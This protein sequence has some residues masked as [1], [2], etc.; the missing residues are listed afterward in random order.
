MDRGLR[1]LERGFC[2]TSEEGGE[3]GR[4]QFEHFQQALGCEQSLVVWGPSRGA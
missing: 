4:G 3:T 1:G 2:G